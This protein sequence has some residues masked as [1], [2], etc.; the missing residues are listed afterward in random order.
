MAPLGEVAVIHGVADT[1]EPCSTPPFAV[2]P[3]GSDTAN[4]LRVGS[5]NVVAAI[6]LLKDEGVA[7]PPAGFGPDGLHP[8]AATAIQ[9][10]TPA[11]RGDLSHHYDSSSDIRPSRSPV[12]S[13]SASTAC[14][15]HW[16]RQLKDRVWVKLTDGGIP[17]SRRVKRPGGVASGPGRLGLLME[18]FAFRRSLAFH[19]RIY[20]PHAPLDVPNLVADNCGCGWARDNVRLPLA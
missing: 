18:W 13:V 15:T 3:G 7:A 4:A 17:K 19:G 14:A 9:S 5:V 10:P 8:E 16:S 20:A 11:T 2:Q 6:G 12:L 1:G